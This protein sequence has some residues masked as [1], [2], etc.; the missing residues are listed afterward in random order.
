MALNAATN[1]TVRIE[2]GGILQIDTV[3]GG[4]QSVGLL[5]PGTLN[6]REPS[7]ARRRE[8]DRGGYTGKVFLGDSRE[9]PLNFDLKVTDVTFNGTEVYNMLVG[10]ESAGEVTPI[11]VRVQV[12]DGKGVNTG[13]QHTFTGVLL[14]DRPEYRA[15]GGEVDPDVISVAATATG[16]ATADWT[17]S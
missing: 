9:G 14:P 15:G 16:Y 13:V 12:R 17:T 5:V 2:S 7:A 11:S 3:A 8:M 10:T 1:K 6:W 4:W